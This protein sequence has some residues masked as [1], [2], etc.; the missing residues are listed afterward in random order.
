M[1]NINLTVNAKELPGVLEVL[2]KEGISLNAAAINPTINTPEVSPNQ[3]L[4]TSAGNPIPPVQTISNQP[5]S[6][7]QYTAQPLPVQPIPVQPMQ[8][9]NYQPL[10][11]QSVNPQP[12]SPQPVAPISFQVG[13]P[14][15]TTAPMTAPTAVPVAGGVPTTAQTYNLDELTHAAGQLCDAGRRPDVL[16]LMASFGIQ[17]MNDL[18][19]DLY[20]AFALKLREMGARI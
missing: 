1:V 7:N 20:S 6:L 17:K 8:P 12:V 5:V 4:E 9:V 2:K 15:P 11:V 19:L 18:R 13:Q 14:I 16:N 3:P 10:P